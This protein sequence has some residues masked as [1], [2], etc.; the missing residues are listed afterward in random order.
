MM[1]NLKENEVDLKDQPIRKIAK[2]IK[3]KDK[4]NNSK[5]IRMIIA[6]YLN[7]LSKG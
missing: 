5:T 6:S 2:K 3:A 1:D 4:A 7:S